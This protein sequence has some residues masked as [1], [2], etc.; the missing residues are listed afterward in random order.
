MFAIILYLFAEKYGTLKPIE[1][2]AAACGSGRSGG[3]ASARLTFQ[4]RPSLV[5]RSEIDDKNGA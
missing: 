3:E 4:G 2:V 1:P 5:P